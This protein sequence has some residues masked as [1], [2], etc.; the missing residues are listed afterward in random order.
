MKE[1]RKLSLSNKKN[2][3]LALFTVFSVQLFSQQFISDTIVTERLRTIEQMLSKGKP[4]ANTWWYGWLIGYSAA[5]MGQGIVMAA[6]DKLGTRQDMA[7]GGIT[8]I[9]GASGMIISPN[10]AG[11][12]PE[13]LAQ[14][15]ENTLEER[16]NKLI[17]AERL[18][19]QSAEREKSAHG[20]QE[21]ALC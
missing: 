10:D 17:E 20:W 11:L 6:S 18:L 13:K 2:L 16:F 21:Q 14:I 5:T 4:N 9:L 1:K 7:L 8:T 12:A 3:I 19:K 15:P